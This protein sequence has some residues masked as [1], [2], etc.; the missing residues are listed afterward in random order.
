LFAIWQAYE[1]LVTQKNPRAKRLWPMRGGGDVIQLRVRHVTFE[2]LRAVR[3]HE[4][5]AVGSD[6]EQAE[7]IRLSQ[8]VRRTGCDR[9]A[10]HAL[11]AR[12]AHLVEHA[13]QIVFGA[14]GGLAVSSHEFPAWWSG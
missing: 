12:G 8:H 10:R 14:H 2:E 1:L 9:H 6:R 13:R 4:S 5:A 3:Q 7:P 11:G